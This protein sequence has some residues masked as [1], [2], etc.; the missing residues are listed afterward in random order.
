M[1]LLLA[2]HR[3]DSYHSISFFVDYTQ[4]DKGVYGSLE[5]RNF[6]KTSNKSTLKIFSE[7]IKVKR[8]KY[9]ANHPQ[10]NVQMKLQ[11]II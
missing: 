3:L 6:L 11:I 10:Q 2:N 1:I 8:S 5:Y 7:L 4:M 9:I